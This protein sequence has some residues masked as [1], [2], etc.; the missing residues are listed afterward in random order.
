[1]YVCKTAPSHCSSTAVYEALYIRDKEESSY[2]FFGASTLGLYP[3][4]KSSEVEPDYKVQYEDS[5][6]IH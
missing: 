5:S 1:M 4:S 6:F 2:L 3:V